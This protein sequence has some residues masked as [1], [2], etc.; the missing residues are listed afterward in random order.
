[1][2]TTPDFN[3]KNAV[4]ELF[5]KALA[6][7]EAEASA[8]AHQKWQAEM[9]R[10][11]QNGDKRR[12]WIWWTAAAALV[13]A[14]ATGSGYWYITRTDNASAESS[15]TATEVSAEKFENAKQ[16]SQVLPHL[17]R[18]KA[19][20]EVPQAQS[21]GIT[22]AI[23]DRRQQQPTIAPPVH[24][25]KQQAETMAN[26]QEQTVEPL[27]PAIEPKETAT[28]EEQLP[29]E[30]FIRL[31]NESSAKGSPS[32]DAPAAEAV[33]ESHLKRLWKR[34]NGKPTV[35]DTAEPRVETRIFGI[36]TDSLFK[37]KNKRK[38]QE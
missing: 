9:A 8:S 16:P 2:K 37:K 5:R 1:M 28:Q 20:E 27:Q 32:A 25:G 10:L 3:D 18:E 11:N 7:Y 14:M 19:K 12:G 35:K 29:L 38:T 17:T 15:P 23:P 13:A 31:G 6:N 4:D 30:V 33:E 26:R 24:T 21:A 34:L 22:A 36:P